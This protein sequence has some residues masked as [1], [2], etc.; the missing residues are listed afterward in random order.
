MLRHPA[1]YA[2]EL[3]FTAPPSFL[4]ASLAQEILEV[5]PKY[6]G[7]ATSY[8]AGQA[9]R[10]PSSDRPLVHAQ[11]PGDFPDCV[12]AM[13]VDSLSLFHDPTPMRIN[14]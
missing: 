14:F 13:L 11:L 7:R 1:R 10:R 9:R 12:A 8:A 3:A 5:T 6:Q 2:V 4:G